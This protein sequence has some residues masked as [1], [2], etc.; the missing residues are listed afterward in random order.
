M[1]KAKNKNVLVVM[2]AILITCIAGFPMLARGIGGD[3]VDLTYHLLRIESVKEALVSGNFPPRVNPLFLEGYGYGSSLFYPDLFLL[4]PALL[5]LV[6]IPPLI[7]YK[8]FMF[9][10]IF[11]ATLTTYYAMNL[12]CNNCEWALLGTGMLILSTF[13]LADINNRSGMSEM[14]ACVF[15]PILMAG[16]YDY[17]A[18]EGKKVYLMGIA[19]VGM[20]LSHTI[21]TFIGLLI[22]SLIFVGMLFVPEKRSLVFEKK[23]LSRLL[24]TAFVAV[25]SVS[26]Y[27]FPMLEQMVNDRFWFNDPWAKIGNYTQPFSTLFWPIGEFAYIAKFGVGIPVLMLLASRIYLG[28]SKNRWA[29]SLVC[30]GVLQFIAMTN[31]IPWWMLQETPINMI[32]FTYRFYPY[33]LFMVICGMLIFLKEKAQ[34]GKIGKKFFVFLVLL[35][36]ACGIWE[37]IYCYQC[38]DREIIDKEYLYTNTS[39]VGRGEWIP[40]GVSR[41]VYK[42]EAEADVITEDETRI[43]F[44]NVDYAKY[45]F[46]ITGTK[47]SRFIVPLL[48]YKGYEAELLMENGQRK[49]L[50]VSK[51]QDGLVA[52]KADGE[53]NGVINVWYE[54]TIVQKISNI[55]SCLVVLVIVLLLIAYK[56]RMGKNEASIKKAKMEML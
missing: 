55:I 29:N 25:L 8:I 52:I 54:G 27:I 17:F 30:I 20:V 33:A 39:K 53:S 23:R 3:L 37:N 36:V 14:M 47:G 32:Q 1:T 12:F 56:I 13:Y 6:G 11:V 2:V 43:P 38:K 10:V 49:V 31:I 26:Y 50:Q 51:S 9:I 40:E 15:L 7:S 21:M 48:Y 44:T 19:F 35:T 41:L 45:Q 28:K 24:L 16:I 46:D 18:A 5:N 4:F 42:G 22:T 34:T